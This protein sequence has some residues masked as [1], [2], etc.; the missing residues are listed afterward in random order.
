[1]QG[2]LADKYFIVELHTNYIHHSALSVHPN[3]SASHQLKVKC[4]CSG[5]TGNTYFF[6]LVQK[7]SEIISSYWSPKAT[8]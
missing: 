5:R 7:T 8:R 6:S 3:L 1:M 2:R 4:L